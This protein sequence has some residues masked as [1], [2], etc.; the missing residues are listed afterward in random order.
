MKGGIRQTLGLLCLLLFIIFLPGFL[1]SIREA[2]GGGTV[3]V[4]GARIDSYN[5]NTKITVNKGESF[6]LEVWFTNTGSSGAN[7]YAGAT[8]WDSSGT[9]IKNLWSNK[10]Y[11]EAGKQGYATLTT[12]ID[13]VGEYWLQFGI[14]NEA[15]T[16]LLARAP[17]PSQ[18]LIKVVGDNP[19]KVEAFDVSPRST[20]LGN[21]FT[22]S[23]TVSDDK[24][25][26]RVELWR[27]DDSGGS[28]VN[29]QKIKEASV[30]GTRYSGSFSDTPTNVGSYWYGIH[31][32]DTAGQWV[33]EPSPIRVTV[34]QITNPTLSK[35]FKVTITPG[36]FADDTIVIS[37][38]NNIKITVKSFTITDY[39]GFNNYGSVTCLTSLPFDIPANSNGEIR[40]RITAN[41]D[42]PPQTFT[43]KYKII[44]DPNNWEVLGD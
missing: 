1:T 9:Q 3:T 28:P 44:G 43:I 34:L 21:T 33:T 2:G 32:V 37:N 38:L 10:I 24:G 29:W 18:N 25:L 14:W 35:T 15:K 31:V 5:P 11:V 30:S 26:T 20:T 41:S 39:G 17:S 8:I 12:S 23:Y 13:T 6:K 42:C 16:T 36:E 22:I 40:V 19:P 7:F 4:I 27:A